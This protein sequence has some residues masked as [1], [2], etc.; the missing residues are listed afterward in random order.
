[1]SRG[2]MSFGLAGLCA[3]LAMVRATPCW[4]TSAPRALLT[5]CS[6]RRESPA[7]AWPPRE[8]ADLGAF[9]AF[10]TR[11]YENRLR[12]LE[13]WNEPDQANELYLAGSDKAQHY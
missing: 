6:T 3:V 10:L 12:A 9:M 5:H 2:R 13:V 4:A 11:R 8:P 7:K 1:M